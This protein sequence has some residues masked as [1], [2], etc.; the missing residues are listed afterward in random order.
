MLGQVRPDAPRTLH[1]EIVRSREKRGI[2]DTRRDRG[3]FFHLGSEQVV[4]SGMIAQRLF[5]L[6]N[7]LLTSKYRHP[8]MS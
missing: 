4:L 2:F 7:G 6:G 3:N 8:G 5:C 1:H